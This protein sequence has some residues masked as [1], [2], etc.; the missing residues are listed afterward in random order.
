MLSKAMK[1]IFLAVIFFSK[2]DYHFY[3][4]LKSIQLFEGM[5]SCSVFHVHLEYQM[6]RPMD[7]VQSRINAWCVSIVDPIS[8]A[9][10]GTS[11]CSDLKTN[12]E[13]DRGQNHRKPVLFF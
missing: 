6:L 7:P 5:F 2:T 3:H 13:I 1:L 11:L 9:I 8:S 10:A 4:Y 12:L